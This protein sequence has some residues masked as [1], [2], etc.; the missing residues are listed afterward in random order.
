ME[1]NFDQHGMVHFQKTRGK[2][3][4]VNDFETVNQQ[5]VAYLNAHQGDLDYVWQ[6]YANNVQTS[7]YIVDLMDELKLPNKED[8]KEFVIQGGYRRGIGTVYV[9]YHMYPANNGITKFGIGTT[10]NSAIEHSKR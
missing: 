4:W 2:T 6:T 7:F 5:I 10:N 1:L 9:N 3:H 8:E